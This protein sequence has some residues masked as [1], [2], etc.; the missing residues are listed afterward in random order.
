MQNPVRQKFALHERRNRKA[1][2]FNE[3]SLRAGPHRTYHSVM[4]RKK[5][6][7]VAAGCSL[8]VVVIG[9][10][11]SAALP[12]GSHW[13][14][15]PSPDLFVTTQPKPEDVT[16]I[17]QLTQ[18]T[19]TPNGLAVLSGK[20][21]ELD[22]RSDGSFSVTNYPRWSP[23]SSAAPP[24]PEFISTAG[25]WRCDSVGAMDNGQPC[26]SV[27]F[28]DA[29]ASMDSLTLRRNGAPYDL[30]FIYGDADEGA[31]ILFGKKK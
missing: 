22:L 6:I 30:M 2:S 12:W 15:V 11:L 18:Q 14:H 1:F 23:A 17:Y 19:I 26:W 3:S 21:C 10:A 31:V 24:T 7:T 5:K 20:M 28:S 9:V 27:V 8:I 4:T 29:P 25:R 16:G 13:P